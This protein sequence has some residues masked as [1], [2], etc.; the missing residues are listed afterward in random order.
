MSV[1]TGLT[2]GAVEVP[3]EIDGNGRLVV[4]GVTGATGFPG[5]QGP[6][7]PN[8]SGSSQGAAFWFA[9]RAWTSSSSPPTQFTKMVWCSGL[10]LFIAAG[11]NTSNTN[12]VATST[13]GVNYTNRLNFSGGVNQLAYSPSLNRVVVAGDNTIRYSNDGITWNNA[14]IATGDWYNVAWSPSLGRFVATLYS[15]TG[16]GMAAYS[17]DGITW[18]VTNMPVT[19]SN[20]YL[21]LTWSPRLNKFFGVPYVGTSVISSSDGITWTKTTMVSSQWQSVTDV[22]ALGL[23]IALSANSP[24]LQT[25]PDGVTWTTR[26]WTGN[27]TQ[28]R[29][30]L[31]YSPELGLLLLGN[32][33]LG[34]VASR[35]GINYTTM[36]NNT[37]PSMNMPNG[38]NDM[39]WVPELF[40]FAGVSQFGAGTLL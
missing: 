23:L 36:D 6:Q 16:T 3:V 8:G 18:T 32:T 1:L 2:S 4:E 17:N 7:G 27:A 28:P 25:S 24:F 12:R 11:Y 14:T 21:H 37:I 19:A 29:G 5:P 33:N 40:K 26:T 34:L 38:F 9:S 15:G 22:P 31:A 30:G 39:V 20:V 13:N 10:S 35:D